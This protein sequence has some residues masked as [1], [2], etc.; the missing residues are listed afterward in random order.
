MKPNIDDE[1]EDFLALVGSSGDSSNLNDGVLVTPATLVLPSSESQEVEHVELSPRETN[2]ASPVQQSHTELPSFEDFK[3]ALSDFY[4]TYNFGNLEKVPYLAERFF[5]RRWD[6]WKQ[7]SVKYRLSPRES[8]NL[9]I[10]FNVKF[11]GI[12]ECTRRLFDSPETVQIS[13]DSLD[14]RRK[15]WIKFLSSSSDS[16]REQ[17]EK[18]VSEILQSGPNDDQASNCIRIDVVRTHQELSFF[19]DVCTVTTFARGFFVGNE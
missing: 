12:P 18:H 4:A 10:R 2:D 11:D 3:D 1:E 14:D 5:F 9:W 7:L 19:Q 17:Y 16:Q 8:V 6:L 13:T 15:I